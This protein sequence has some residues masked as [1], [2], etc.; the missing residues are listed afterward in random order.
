VT[1]TIAT[2]DNHADTNVME[3]T[4]IWGARARRR[5]FTAAYKAGILDEYDALPAGGDRRGALLRREGLY[6]SQIAEWRKARDAGARKGSKAKDKPKR[7][8]EQVELEELRRRDKQLQAELKRT[9]LA[10]Q[11][12]AEAHALLEIFWACH[13]ICPSPDRPD[14]GPLLGEQKECDED[15]AVAAWRGDWP[16][17]Y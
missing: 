13:S 5:T 17:P 2:L 6:S 14:I 7:T 3:G 12:T 1:M 16:P 10:L 9:R 4:P 11:I 8:A 15:H